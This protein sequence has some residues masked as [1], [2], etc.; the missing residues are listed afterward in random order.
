M[1]LQRR[2][3]NKG[4]VL[5]TGESQRKNLTYMYRWE[6]LKGKK[7]TIYAKTLN[8]LREKEKE[9]QNELLKGISRSDSTLNEQIEFYLNSKKDLAYSTHYNYVKYYEKHIKNS[10]LG[11]M[12]IYKIKKSDVIKFYM[13]CSENGLKKGSIL[14]LHKII[15]PSLE[16]AIDDEII[17]R[18][19]S[20]GCTKNLPN[21]LEQGY[22]LTIE[23]QKEFISRIRSSP[24]MRRYAPMY[25]IDLQLGLRLGELLG[26]TWQDVDFEESIVHI[27]HQIQY[28][29]I[30]DKAQF[31][32]TSLK[33]EGSYRDIPMSKKVLSLFKE[34]RKIW[35]ATCKD[36][37]FKVDGYENFI[38]LSNMTGKVV[39]PAN[40]RRQ[41]KRIAQ[42]DK[43]DVD[44][45]QNLHPHILRHTACTRMAE[46]SIDIRT[47][48][49]LMGHSKLETTM[50][51]YN[52]VDMD[53]VKRELEKIEETRNILEN[54]IV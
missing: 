6:D 1:F 33:T 32:I 15:H 22:A 52:H 5:N 38:F 49:Y 45:P 41:M 40:I 10:V 29:P 37:N 8:E 34:Q 53:R 46:S 13:K 54:G 30:N 43:I 4:R 51:I 16:L 47:L 12:E 3:D 48:Q 20:Y 21:D 11:N 28:R 31:Y 39:Y 23:E 24:K 44:L 7:K 17:Q 18:N 9:I 35:M 36:I 26:L 25:E 14:I 27:N 42:M 19:P 50:K 2:K